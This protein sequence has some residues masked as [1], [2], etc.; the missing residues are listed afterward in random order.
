MRQPQEVPVCDNAL[1]H[2]RQ[3]LAHDGELHVI[4]RRQVSRRHI[5]QL[6]EVEEHVRR[7]V[8]CPDEAKS[9]SARLLG[10]L[11]LFYLDSNM[12]PSCTICRGTQCDKI[13]RLCI[14]S[15]DDR[16]I[17]LK[18]IACHMGIVGT[19]SMPLHVATHSHVPKPCHFRT[20]T[21]TGE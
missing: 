15:L 19:S 12:H 10:F 6:R 21:L 20:M 11:Q 17:A 2:V 18:D 1:G 4:A 16:S 14:A 13:F 9:A 3:R 8:A 7:T 5:R